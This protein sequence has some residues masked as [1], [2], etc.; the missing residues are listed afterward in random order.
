MTEQYAKV[1]LAMGDRNKLMNA[2][3]RATA[4]ATELA[5][6]SSEGLALYSKVLSVGLD[7]QNDS[8][9]D[10][11]SYLS[12]NLYAPA[13]DA[14]LPLPE[15]LFRFVHNHRNDADSNL[16]DLDH[17]WTIGELVAFETA[18]ALFGKRF[19]TIARNLA[20]QEDVFSPTS[21]RP[22]YSDVL[23][24]YKKYKE[25]TNY[26]RWKTLREEHSTGINKRYSFDDF[27]EKIVQKTEEVFK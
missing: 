6:T 4:E 12:A 16:N 23:A 9:L 18:L 24:F 26:Q 7:Y 8:F 20:K 5:A 3:S 13:K 21:A 15:I 22:S 14:V 1:L 17:N 2:L 25:T 19:K 10:I 11:V 27:F